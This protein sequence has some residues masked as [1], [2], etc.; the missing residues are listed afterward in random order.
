MLDKNP[1]G[2]SV[3]GSNGRDVHMVRPVVEKHGRDGKGKMKD[4]RREAELH[5]LLYI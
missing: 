2:H 3:K 4:T 1:I 5:T